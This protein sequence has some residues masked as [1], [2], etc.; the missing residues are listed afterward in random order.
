MRSRLTVLVSCLALIAGVL[1]PGT[2]ASA[3]PKPIRGKLSK[4][5][6]TLIALADSGKARVVRVRRSRFAVRPPARVV[7]LQ[8]RRPDGVYA[9][10]VVVGRRERGTRAIVGV[11]AGTKLGRVRVRR[12]YAT[13][14]KR[15]G[16]DRVLADAL[17]RARRGKPIGAGKFGRVRSR[18]VR[19]PLPAD[20]D[21][22]GIPDVL[23]V[24]V[25]GDLVLDAVDSLSRRGRS[26]QAPESFGFFSRLTLGI[27][28]TANANATG[29]SG[30]QMDA[31]LSA[32]S[33][34]LLRVLSSESDPNY[35]ELDCGGDIQEPPRPIGLAY[36]RPHAPPSNGIGTVLRYSGG[37]EQP[38]PD[39]CDLDSDGLG[40]LTADTSP[41][42]TPATA[43]TLHHNADSSEIK[44]GD[45]M[46]QHVLRNGVDTAFLAKLQYVFASS[47]A[48]MSYRG[49]TGP[50]R[51]V[52]YPYTPKADPDGNGPMPNLPAPFEVADGND[53][54]DD[55]SVTLTFW[56]PQR[57]PV[58]AWGETAP[59]IDIG[60]LRYEVQVEYSGR[61][62]P[63]GAF[64]E[65]DDTIALNTQELEGPGFTDQTDDQ[66]ANPN[67]TL[68]YTLNLSQCLEPNGFSFEPGRTR[69]FSF[70]AVNK[71][72]CDNAQQGIWFKRQP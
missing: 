32:H 37:N 67:N 41:L 17:V 1:V 56:R 33:D 59:W 24:D 50:T 14:R 7:T 3:A 51:T 57:S 38:F 8:L 40:K 68:T 16:D 31:A 48:V 58:A 62:C 45:V 13:V 12:G 29:L 60:R 69:G 54:G 64:S 4:P 30:A 10:P 5:G 34:L 70:L 49:E 42:G 6:Y 43:M 46:I 28:Q 65:S 20:R 25:D 71:Q 47:P 2:S 21:L 9:G 66:A 27:D 18:K 61:Q 36:C 23:D 11:R 72:C 44:T 39:C 19:D 52:E 63:Q 35:P 53:A 22:D 15:L 55:V 26:A